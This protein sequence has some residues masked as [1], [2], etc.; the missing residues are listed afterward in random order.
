MMKMIKKCLRNNQLF[1][2]ILR[3]AWSW[4]DQFISCHTNNDYTLLMNTRLLDCLFSI[5]IAHFLNNLFSQ[6]LYHFPIFLASTNLVFFTFSKNLTTFIFFSIILV[7]FSFYGYKVVFLR[8]YGAKDSV[9]EPKI[10]E[11]K[12]EFWRRCVKSSRRTTKEMN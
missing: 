12:W 6:Q 3:L 7:S 10:H 9:V 1:S 5:F 8:D 2:I 4:V 11:E